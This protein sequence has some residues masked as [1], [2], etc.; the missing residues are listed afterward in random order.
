MKEKKMTPTPKR[1]AE[2]YRFEGVLEKLLINHE[3]SG[4]LTHFLIRR[5][6]PPIHDIVG[7]ISNGVKKTAVLGMLLFFIY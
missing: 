1:G 7:R 4:V 3:L 5:M 2:F 6:D